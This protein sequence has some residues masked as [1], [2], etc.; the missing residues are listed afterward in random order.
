LILFRIAKNYEKSKVQQNKKQE[1]KDEKKNVGNIWSNFIDDEDDN[2][3]HNIDFIKKEIMSSGKKDKKFISDNKKSEF[4]ENQMNKIAKN[5][6]NL[7][8]FT[9]PEDKGDGIRL[10]GKASVVKTQVKANPIVE[11]TIAKTSGYNFKKEVE[12][13]KTKTIE[14]PKEMD[15]YDTSM[16]KSIDAD[17]EDENDFSNRNK[18][19]N[20]IADRY[21]A[22]SHYKSPNYN[23]HESD[24]EEE[25][26]DFNDDDE[27]EEDT[28]DILKAYKNKSNY[29]RDE[30]DEV[31]IVKKPDQSKMFNKYFKQI[32]KEDPKINKTQTI[33]KPAAKIE[34]DNPINE[35]L[36]EKLNELNKEI[37]KFKKE[38]EKVGKLKAEYDRL[39]K[40]INRE[41]EDFNKRKENEMNEFEQYKA[42][43]LKKIEKERKVMIRNAKQLQNQPNRKEREEIESLKEQLVKLQDDMKAKDQRNKLAMDRLKKQLEDTTKK[44]EELQKELKIMEEQRIKNMPSA[45]SRDKSKGKNLSSSNLNNTNT[46]ISSISGNTNANICGIPMQP[47]K[48]PPKKSKTDLDMSDEDY[49]PVRQSTS[50]MKQTIENKYSNQINEFKDNSFEEIVIKKNNNIN[51]TSINQ[52]PEQKKEYSINK[53]Q[54]PEHKKENNTNHMRTPDTNK[55][56][57]INK[58]D[59]PEPKKQPTTQNNKIEQEN[60]EEIYE[61]EFPEKYHGKTSKNA[62]LITQEILEDGK[63][64][65]LYDNGKREILFPS[66][67]VKEIFED[68][69]QITYLSNKD[70]KQVYPDKREIYL[71]HKENTIQFKYPDGIQVYKFATNQLEKHFPDGTKQVIYPDGILRYVYTDG[72]EEIFFPDGTLQKKSLDGVVTNEYS[73]GIKV[74]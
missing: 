53:T 36:S 38:N 62:R 25:K 28:R 73:D 63:I 57:N 7:S 45:N 59:I 74:I 49:G 43:E 31:D 46:T 60:D 40:K 27:E 69:Y 5:M 15:Y 35:I 1:K 58:L 55:Q 14:I 13:V 72:T 67:A 8:N 42:E 21:E 51:K 11:H 66:G 12:T 2:S 47:N 20:N 29:N 6:A 70:I 22:D 26:K 37:D 3:D 54:I 68:G 50:S 61:M 39:T 23:Y 52:I 30:D 48:N 9:P 65:K 16:N 10:Y 64:L 34:D 18:I 32:P 71:F 44:N 33:T 4:D 24:N 17:K 41:I 19:D 56:Y